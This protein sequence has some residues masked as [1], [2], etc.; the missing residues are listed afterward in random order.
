MMKIIVGSVPNY[1]HPVL[2]PVLDLG[3]VTSMG[4]NHWFAVSA[5]ADAPPLSLPS[6]CRAVLVI[7]ATM[8]DVWKETM[9]T[10][11]MVTMM[12]MGTVTHTSTTI[13]LHALKQ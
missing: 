6:H 3:H 9:A 2:L 5:I 4:V 10:T 11:A 12:A 8:T 1:D 13:T 7:V